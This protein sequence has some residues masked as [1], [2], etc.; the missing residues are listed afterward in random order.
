MTCVST[1]A[2]VWAVLGSP[3]APLTASSSSKHVTATLV[4]EYGSVEPGHPLSVGLHLKMAP[5]WH[6]YWKNPGDS[7]LPTRI[8]WVLPTGVTAG[9]IEW[10]R[11]HRFTLGGLTSYAYEHE[12]L[13]L[14]RLDVPATLAGK[15]LQVR[16]QVKWLECKEQ[17]IPGRAELA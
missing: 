2:L 3:A 1:F 4:P 9:P 12:V 8:A 15:D 11:P 7:G 14:T 5:E 6:T 17:C 10:P 13:L 16:A